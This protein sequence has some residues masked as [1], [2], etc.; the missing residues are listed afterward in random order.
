MIRLT[1]KEMLGPALQVF[2]LGIP[3]K[4]GGQ[5]VLAVFSSEVSRGCGKGHVAVRLGCA[6]I[7]NA[8]PGLRC[9]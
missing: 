7:S 9:H 4:C 1:P 6:G 5:S 3:T 8:W 2:L